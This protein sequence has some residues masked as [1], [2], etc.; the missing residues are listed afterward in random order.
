M[1]SA[2]PAPSAGVIVK[3]ALRLVRPP[4]LASNTYVPAFWMARP[5]KVAMPVVSV[6]AVAPATAMPP[7][8]LNVIA[9]PTIGLEL[10]S[11]RLTVTAGRI[12]LPAS[13][14]LGCRTKAMVWAGPARLVRL[15]IA[16]GGTPVTLAVTAYAPVVTLAVA[17]TLATP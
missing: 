2:E 8:R 4:P 12:G 13:A 5:G 1:V 9:A 17:V 16:G 14:S 11:V 15:N 6:F 7:G 3:D 10:P